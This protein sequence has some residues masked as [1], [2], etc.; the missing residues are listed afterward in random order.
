MLITLHTGMKCVTMD[1]NKSRVFGI[2]DRTAVGV[3]ED[4]ISSNG[5]SGHFGSRK[6]LEY[7]TGQDKIF[8]R[9]GSV[10]IFSRMTA[11]KS[12]SLS[13]TSNSDSD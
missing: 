9:C 8:Y 6:L 1:E 3:V 11:T 13:F 7:F 2:F 5:Q 4:D 10:Y 12:G